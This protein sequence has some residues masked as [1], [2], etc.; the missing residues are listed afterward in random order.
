MLLPIM[1][2]Q[3]GAIE[4]FK[5]RN[6]PTIIKVS[7][8]AGRSRFFATFDVSWFNQGIKLVAHSRGLTIY[9]PRFPM[10]KFERESYT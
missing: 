5:S 7:K 6:R 3:N 10:L 8:G 1:D 2:R 4:N 9:T